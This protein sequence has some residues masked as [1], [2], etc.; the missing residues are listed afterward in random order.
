MPTLLLQ[1]DL[2]LRQLP[3]LAGPKAT[4]SNDFTSTYFTRTRWRGARILP[5]DDDFLLFAST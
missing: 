5:Y 1:D 3:A 4:L 2:G